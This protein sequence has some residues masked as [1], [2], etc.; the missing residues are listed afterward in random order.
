M[1]HTPGPLYAELQDEETSEK[2]YDI[3]DAVYGSVAH[4]SET[5]R[6]DEGMRFLKGDAY[7]FAAVPDLYE[8]CKAAGAILWI[9][10][11]YLEEGGQLGPEQR[12]FDEV[13]PLIRAALNKAEGKS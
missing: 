8:A 6:S 4:L 5:A 7:L 10:E 2:W 13:A 3:R 9:A 1:E 11:K 12:N